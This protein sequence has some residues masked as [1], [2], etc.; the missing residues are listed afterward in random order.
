MR[1]LAVPWSHLVVSVLSAGW[2]HAQDSRS[3]CAWSRASWTGPEQRRARRRGVHPAVQGKPGPS[4]VNRGERAPTRR[5]ARHHPDPAQAHPAMTETDITRLCRGPASS[6]AGLISW[7]PLAGDEPGLRGEN[8]CFEFVGGN[9][10]LI[11]P[12]EHG[13]EVARVAGDRPSDLVKHKI[14]VFAEPSCHEAV[15]MSAGR[16]AGEEQKYRNLV[17]KAG[18]RCGSR[19]VPWSPRHAY[20]ATGRSS[21]TLL[22]AAWSWAPTLGAASSRRRTRKGPSPTRPYPQAITARNER[23]ASAGLTAARTQARRTAVR[24]RRSGSA[25]NIVTCAGNASIQR[26]RG[27]E[28]PSCDGDP[29]ARHASTMWRTGPGITSTNSARMMTISRSRPMMP[30]SPRRRR[31]TAQLYA[32]GPGQPAN[33]QVTG[34]AVRAPRALEAGQV[35]RDGA[36]R[37]PMP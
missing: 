3:Y 5:S 20:A 32:G 18:P 8:A 10:E 6:P 31:V 37:A 7:S 30:P 12:A 26:C 35:P 14:G 4:A 24:S 21:A 19:A 34:D 27:H 25:A 15:E 16:V 13:L 28:M 11:G 33:E 29:A 17:P 36:D 9:S 23:S 2:C 1:Y 22:A